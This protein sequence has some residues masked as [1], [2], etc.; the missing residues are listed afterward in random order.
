MAQTT[1]AISFVASY[2]AIS[3]DGASWTNASGYS[4]QIEISG[5]D[6]QTGVAYTAD[7]DTAIITGGKREP[8][9]ITING[10][11]TENANELY[12]EANDAYETAGGAGNFYVRW[13]PAGNTAGNLQY[14]TSVGIVTAPVYP[15]GDAGNGDPIMVSVTIKCASVTEA[16]IV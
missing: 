13:A 10:V 7:G 14:T 11:D 1:D 6:R 15:V 4:H 2:L 3:T 9:D 5:G 16:T 8:L 12:D